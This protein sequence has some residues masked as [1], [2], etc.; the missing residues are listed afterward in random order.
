VEVERGVK[1]ENLI[2][3]FCDAVYAVQS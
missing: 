3:Q 1:D 2:K